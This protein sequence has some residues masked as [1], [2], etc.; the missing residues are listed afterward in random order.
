[1]DKDQFT[2]IE[3][4]A[5][6]DITLEDATQVVPADGGDTDDSR[7]DAPVKSMQREADSESSPELGQSNLGLCASSRGH[8][9]SSSGHGKSSSGLTMS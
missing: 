4:V 2:N 7:T 6:E 5:L 8:V 9:K 3:D 1:M